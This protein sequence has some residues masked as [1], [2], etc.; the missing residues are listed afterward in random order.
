VTTVYYTSDTHL[1]HQKVSE[2]RGFSSIE[3]HD[4][5]LA[6]SWDRTVKKEDTV[7][8]LGDLT[9]KG[10]LD[11]MLA[12]FAA[13]PG[14]KHLIFGNHDSGHPMHRAAHKQQRKYLTVF[15][16]TNAFARVR[17]N[18]KGVLLSHFPYGDTDHTD[19]A[20]YTQYR[21]PDEG[22][23]LLHGHTHE[24]IIKY[25]DHSIHVGLDAWGLNMPSMEEIIYFMENE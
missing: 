4:E 8:V 18:G 14:T 11:Y 5:V 23:W 22:E 25:T 13:R 17:I 9:M 16:S 20:R 15:Q 12:W 2:L 6:I 10:N 3:E 1:Q 19:I 21:L 24:S 7:W